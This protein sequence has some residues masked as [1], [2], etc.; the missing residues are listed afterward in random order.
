MKIAVMLRHFGRWHETPVVARQS[1]G[2][3]HANFSLG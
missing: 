3:P 1:S 2:P